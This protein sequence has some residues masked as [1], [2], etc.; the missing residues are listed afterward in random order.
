MSSVNAVIVSAGL[1]AQQTLAGLSS[2]SLRPRKRHGFAEWIANPTTEREA[3]DC[4]S[5]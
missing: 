3:A 4:F 1:E 5:E 2:E